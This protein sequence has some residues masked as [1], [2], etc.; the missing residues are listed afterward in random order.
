MIIEGVTYYRFRVRFRLVD[1]RRRSW[2][3]WSPALEW[4]RQEVGREL[5]ESF[6]SDGVKPH[7][8]TIEAI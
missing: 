8:C 6:G 3:R 2:V 7:S 5:Y 1:G 4:A